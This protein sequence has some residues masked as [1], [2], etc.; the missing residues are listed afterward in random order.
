MPAASDLAF[1]ITGASTGVGYETASSLAASGK[2]VIVTARTQDKADDSI[3]RLRAAH[4]TLELNLTGYPLEL[5]DF[6]SIEALATTLAAL[7]SL[8]LHCLICNAGSNKSGECHGLQLLWVNNYLGHFHLT[9][10][11]L[12]L[13]QRTSRSTGVDS[14]VVQVSSVMHRTTSAD[15]MLRTAIRGDSSFQPQSYS[16][17]K[18][19]QVMLA[20]ELQRRYGTRQQPDGRVAAVAVN[21]G[22][23]NSS[24]WRYIPTPLTYIT[25]PLFRLLML[26]PAQGAHTSVYAATVP[27]PPEGRLDYLSPYW[28][29]DWSQWVSSLLDWW[30]PGFLAAPT[31]SE[32][33]QDAYDE[34]KCRVLWELS[35]QQC[36]SITG[37]DCYRSGQIE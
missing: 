21:P 32:A 8:Q 31:K 29:V 9:R 33:N 3:R 2:R 5:T 26:T 25:G 35:E 13:L 4:P 12:P 16:C 1:L 18:L 34:E 19:A 15:N 22:A 27:P 28:A 11:L 23:V 30:M 6:A 14:V 17:S 24:I 7:P 37:K 20:F 10:L 36:R